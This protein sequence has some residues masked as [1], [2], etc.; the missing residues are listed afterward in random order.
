MPVV[1]GSEVFR[2]AR[3]YAFAKTFSFNQKTGVA[4]IE[5][6]VALQLFKAKLKDSGKSKV[7][8]DGIGIPQHKAAKP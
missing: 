4:V 1:G 8:F 7:S 6:N 2:L 5:Y 3:G